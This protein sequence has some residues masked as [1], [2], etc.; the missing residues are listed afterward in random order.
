M[1]AVVRLA[2]RLLVTG[3]SGGVSFVETRSVKSCLGRSPASIAS[4][5]LPYYGSTGA[6]SSRRAPIR[7]AAVCRSGVIGTNALVAARPKTGMLA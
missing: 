2:G 6:W 3:Y 7:E 4:L 1:G 5:R